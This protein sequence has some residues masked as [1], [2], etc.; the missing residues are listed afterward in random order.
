MQVELKA[1][2][3]DVGITFVFVTHDQDE[4]LTLCDRLAVMRDGRLEQVGAAA[5]VYES[6]ATRFVAEFV[7]TSNVIAGDAAQAILG[8]PA[9]VAVRPEKI[10]IAPRGAAQG[11]LRVDATV[12]EIVYAGSQTRVVTD[13]EHGLTLSALVL[14]TS[15]GLPKLQRGDSVTLTWERA[16][17]RVLE[18]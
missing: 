8:S 1:I 12:R 10:A 7:G 16:A 11:E 18:T 3:R 17:A 9:P 13:A 14:N 5:E 6:P 15:V 4:A 2:Q